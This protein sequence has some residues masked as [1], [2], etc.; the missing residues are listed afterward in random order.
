VEWQPLSWP[1]SFIGSAAL[2]GTACT[3]GPEVAGTADGSG[4][5]SGT[6]TATSAADAT[7]AESDTGTM[8]GC[9]DGI[10][11]AGEYCFERIDLEVPAEHLAV[12][13]FDDDGVPDI[14]TNYSEAGVGTARV[15]L[16]RSGADPVIGDPVESS[17]GSETDLLVGDYDGDGDEDLLVAAPFELRLLP[18]DGTG[19]LSAGIVDDSRIFWPV[20]SID[21][22][23]DG[24]DEIVAGTGSGAHLEIYSLVQDTWEG[25]DEPYNMSACL[26]YALLSFDLDGDGHGDVVEVGWPGE[27]PAFPD[28]DADLIPVAVFR[29]V[30]DGSLS[31]VAEFET[32]VKPVQA[33]AGDLNDDG[34][35]D[36]AVVNQGAD[37][38]VLLGIG[39]ASFAPQQRLEFDE[40]GTPL[41]SVAIGDVDGEGHDELLVIVDDHLHAVRA[42]LDAGEQ[43]ELAETTR[44][45]ALADLNADGVQD[46]IFLRPG[47]PQAVSV[48]LSDP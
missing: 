20:Q 8:A 3:C 37:I 1:A 30:G 27:C 21:A 14:A 34:V 24:R 13:D 4:S 41:R 15:V 12:G 44:P 32:G 6:G 7:T 5:G 22:D 35:A 43:T 45:V 38:S 46:V 26:A 33:S 11:V 17:D 10:P 36:L 40:L 18:N 31:F 47:T 16:W 39:Q 25:T 23:G 2:L 9:G 48:L 29:G 19:V 28:Y 42:P